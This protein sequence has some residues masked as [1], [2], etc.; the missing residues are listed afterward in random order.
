M[1]GQINDQLQMMDNQTDNFTSLP[2]PTSAEASTPLSPAVL[3]L[4]TTLITLIAIFIVVGDVFSI[5]V[6]RRIKDLAESSKI[7]MISLASNDLL[8]GL[9]AIPT[10]VASALDHWPFGS[11]V[12][13]IQGFVALTSVTLSV[14]LICLL[15]LERYVAVTHPFRFQVWF[16]RRNVLAA[17]TVAA[18]LCIALV[19]I[20]IWLIM[21]MSY[22]PASVLCIG[23][24][25]TAV[26]EITL[27]VV[28]AVAPVVIMVF[29]YLRLIHISRQHARK[30][31]AQVGGQRG[32]QKAA[33]SLGPD[34][35]AVRTFLVV[36]VCFALC[37]MPIQGSRAYAAVSG[38]SLPNWLVFVTTWLAASNS[39]FNVCIYYVFN[40]SFRS[41]ARRALNRLRCGKCSSV[42]PV[43]A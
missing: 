5:V 19:V 4:R 14:C 8:V 11:I 13:S 17:V 35:K 37:W 36:T 15:N 42:G 30:I 23:E 26:L 3:A 16:Q 39:F 29:I 10:I 1:V 20:R 34:T 6:V 41:E 31:Q 12:C 32:V 38:S 21:P 22:I 2:Q 28:V 7:L 18:I 33:R 40:A 43:E 25:G 9:Y 24:H 27:T